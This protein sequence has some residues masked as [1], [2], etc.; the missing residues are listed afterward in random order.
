MEK[1]EILFPDDAEI[2]RHCTLAEKLFGTDTDPDQA[3]PTLN[4]V[5][6]L[7]AVDPYTYIYTENKLETMGWSVVLPTT[8]E[9]MDSFFAE[10]ITE[11][12]LF[13]I[14]T[15]KPYSF[16]VLYLTAAVTL[17]EFQ[18][19]GIASYLMK[20][21]IHYFTKKYGTKDF[22]A[23]ILTDEGLGLLKKIERELEITIHY[24]RN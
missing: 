4:N 20:S 1:L 23:Y 12:E 11:K 14:G 13:D 22:F 19:K 10:K 5:K 3:Q 9:N 7:I 24:I 21:Q 8:K 15:T 16:E 2:I 17:P 18:N 6:R